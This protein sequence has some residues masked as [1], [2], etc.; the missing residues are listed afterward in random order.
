MEAKRMDD[1]DKGRKSQKQIGEQ[2]RI[3]NLT[4][5][6]NRENVKCISWICNKNKDNGM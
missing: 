5:M 2:L 4:H 3:N 6:T 1:A